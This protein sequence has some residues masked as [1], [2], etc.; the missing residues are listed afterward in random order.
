MTTSPLRILLHGFGSY[1]I[2]FR[3][4]IEL[5][6]ERGSD[7]EWSTIL[8]TP[9]HLEHMRK[10]LP[11]QAILS[12]AAHQAP[13]P[14][15]SLDLP[16]LASYPGNVFADIEAE[17]IHFKHRPAQE[18]RARAYEI[19]RIYKDFLARVRP[20]HVL[21]PQIEG[22][23]GKMLVGLAAE[24]GAQV[25]APVIGRNLGGSYFSTDALE[26]LPGSRHATPETLAEADAFIERFRTR[27]TSA[28]GLPEGFDK[29][30]PPLPYPLKPL[31]ARALDYLKRAASTPHLYEL[32]TLRVALLNNLPAVRDRIWATRRAIAIRQHDIPPGGPLPSKFIYYPLQVTPESSIN[33]PSPYFVDQMRAIDVIRFAMPN[34]H[35]LLV[36]EHPAAILVRK[37]SF[38]RALRR[39]AGVVVAHVSTDS[40]SLVRQA[41]CTISVTGSASLE[42]FLLG[43][44]S[45]TLGPN[46]IS[47]YLGGVAQVDQ[48]RERIAEAI[49]HPPPDEL[50]RRAVAEIFSVRYEFVLRA[51]GSPGE[52]TLRRKN[53]ERL[54]D[55]IVDHVRRNP[56]ARGAASPGL[57]AAI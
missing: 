8:P 29:G 47:T 56:P 10:V 21:V 1:P 19:Y 43:R 12:L 55:A 11:D 38:I 7:I 53:L 15:L 37:L 3:Y 49:A 22:Y 31:A 16:G 44:P 17:K 26:T 14:D 2:V 40:L 54:L 5:A 18:Q 36:K 46:L 13:K 9:V 24:M 32:D 48:L 52:P 20:T 33:T 41:A 23:E 30:D 27:A 45:L 4:L 39:R 28:S 51:P 34:D 57:A 35:V 6:R 50:V 42:A 25:M